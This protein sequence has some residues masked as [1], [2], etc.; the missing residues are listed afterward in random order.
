[1]KKC[2][3]ILVAVLMASGLTSTGM[4]EPIK[5]RAQ[6]LFAPDDTSTV[7]QAQSVVDV[8]NRALKG[9]LETTLYQ[10]GQ[11]VPP[12]EMTAA[13]SRGVYDAA[14]MVPMMRSE[15]GAVA[16]G[17]PFSLRGIDQI[18]EFWYDYGFL[19]FMRQ[20]DARKGVRFGSPLPF[21][22]VTLLSK[23]PVNK[24]DDMKGKKIWA[25]GPMAHLTKALGAEPVWFDPG[26]VY[27][28]LRLG[29][30]DGIFFGVAELETM[31]LKE[32]VKYVMSPAPIDILVCDWVIGLRSWNKLTPA[33][34]ATYDEAMKNNVVDQYHRSMVSNNK[35]LEAGK[36]AGV[37]VIEIAESELPRFRAAAMKTWEELRK[38]DAMSAQAVKM[39]EDYLRSKGIE[40]GK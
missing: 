6:T 21:G 20:V 31:K 40:P 22:P 33:M 7:I 17:L 3:K 38:K 39:V 37:Q 23:F 10:S 35:G 24:L 9:R 12:E 16:F 8:T 29:T 18:M 1:M 11:L 30:I 4:A 15:A 27:M 2:M 28:G 32:V 19:D 14:A 5:W 13:L 36:A 25:E 34:Q 26:E